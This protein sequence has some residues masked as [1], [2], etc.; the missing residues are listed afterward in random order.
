MNEFIDLKKNFNIYF[1]K[2]YSNVMLFPSLVKLVFNSSFGLK[3]LNNKYVIDF[4]SEVSKITCQ[5][6]ILIKSKVSISNF[7][8]KKNNYISLKV[9]LRK[10]NMFSFI[11]KFINLSV[12][13]I[14]DFRGFNFSSV[15]YNGNFNFG[16]SDHCIF[17]EMFLSEKSILPKGFNINIVTKSLDRS[18]S[19]KL[20]KFMGFPFK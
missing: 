9:T 1:G 14:A 2:K 3:G 8:L 13:R 11:S 6:P 20:F 15:D 19:L 4:I 5:K 10:K 12:P 16:F 18:D 7:G 17:P